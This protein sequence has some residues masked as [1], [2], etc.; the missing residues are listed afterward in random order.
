MSNLTRIRRISCVSG[1]FIAAMLC[2]GG[3][4]MQQR[5][6]DV[7][8]PTGADE[9]VDPR[10]GLTADAQD[11]SERDKELGYGKWKAKP[12]PEGTRAPTSPTR[13]GSSWGTVD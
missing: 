10:F 8:Q 9:Q 1:V 3:C 5:R 6:V 12:E 2:L 7:P 11:P 4:E 13:R